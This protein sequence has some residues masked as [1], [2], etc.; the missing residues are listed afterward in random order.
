VWNTSRKISYGE[1]EHFFQKGYSS[2]G[3]QR[4]LGLYHVK[5][6]CIANDIDIICEN[7]ELNGINGIAFELHIRK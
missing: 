7:R 1:I 5:K 4:G 2:K 3:E 6:I